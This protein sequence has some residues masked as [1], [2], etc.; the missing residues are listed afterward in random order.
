MPSKENSKNIP[1]SE[2]KK[3]KGETKMSSKTKRKGI[4][5]KLR[6]EIFKRDH[7]KCQYCGEMAPDVVLNV[8]HIVPIAEGG[9][10]DILNLIT[11]CFDCNS[12]KSDIMLTDRK[13]VQK[14][15]EKLKILAEK[16]EQLELMLEWRTE[17]DDLTNF[18]ISIA[19]NEIR[20]YTDVFTLSETNRH[21]MKLLIQKYSLNLVLESIEISFSRYYRE[22]DKEN[23]L[24][25]AFEKI[26]GI[27]Y[28]KRKIKNN[29]EYL[30]QSKAYYV[31]KKKFPVY[32]GTRVREIIANCVS[33]DESLTKFYKIID[34]SSNWSDFFRTIENSTA[35]EVDKAS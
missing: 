1:K 31:L 32:N 20:K 5:K 18:E 7:F 25:F 30:F 8:D 33:D 23:S 29:P 11:A 28:I 16:K 12:G 27:C 15:Q 24:N 21:R 34:T 3:N 14:Q 35:N 2:N 17:L 19:E 13:E 4:S 22:D 9:D 6:F 10:N 26:G